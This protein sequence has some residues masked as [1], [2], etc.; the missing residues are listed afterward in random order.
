MAQY[1]LKS[2]FTAGEIAPALYGRPDLQYYAA[3]ARRLENFCV[4]PYGGITKRPGAMFMNMPYEQNDPDSIRLIPFQYSLDDSYMLEFGHKYMSVYKDGAPVT[5][6]NIIRESSGAITDVYVSTDGSVLI[7]KECECWVFYNEGAQFKIGT[8]LYT[9]TSRQ[10]WA[11]DSDYIQLTVA[12]GID[13][14]ATSNILYAYANSVEQGSRSAVVRWTKY[15]NSQNST[16]FD[17]FFSLGNV[18]SVDDFVFTV[19]G[20]NDDSNNVPVATA[21]YWRITT[22]LSAN[23]SITAGSSYR[24]NPFIKTE[25]GTTNPPPANDTTSTWYSAKILF[26]SSSAVDK[27]IVLTQNHLGQMMVKTSQQYSDVFVPGFSFSYWGETYTVEEVE[28]YVPDNA[29]NILILDKT[30]LSL[31]STINVLLTVNLFWNQN[32]WVGN[33]AFASLMRVGHKFVNNGIVYTIIADAP[34]VEDDG[35]VLRVLTAEPT[36]TRDS[37]IIRYDLSPWRESSAGLAGWYDIDVRVDVPEEPYVYTIGSP[38]SAD[39]LKDVSYAQSAD[40]LYLVSPEKVPYE[41]SRYGS[42]DW[43]FATFDYKDGPFSARTNADLDVSITFGGDALSTL[44]SEITAT[45]SAPMFTA[46]HVGALLTAVQSVDALTITSTGSTTM[47]PTTDTTAISF[48]YSNRSSST[49][50]ILVTTSNAVGLLSVGLDITIVDGTTNYIRTITAITQHSSGTYVTLN[51]PISGAVIGRTVTVNAQTLGSIESTLNDRNN[52][53]IELLCFGTWHV[54]THGFW[55]GSLA[56]QAFSNEENRWINLSIMNSD[57]DTTTGLDGSNYDLSGEVSEA[58]IIRVIPL[59]FFYAFTPTNN[60]D[61]SQGYVTLSRPSSLSRGIMKITD[62]LSN[63]MANGV[64]IQPFLNQGATTNWQQGAWSDYQ[65]YPTSVGF[66]EER[67]IFAATRREPQTVWFS[68]TGDYNNFGVS[69]PVV[70]DDAIT[71]TLSSRQLNKIEAIINTNNLILMT[72]STEWKITAASNGAI[73]PTNFSARVQGA[74]GCDILEPLIINSV[75]LFVQSKGSKVQDLLYSFE[76]DLYQGTD[77]SIL[78]PHIFS[79]AKVRDWCYQQEPNSIIWIV[80]D[81]GM[82]VSLTYMREHNVVAWARHPLGADATVHA[83]GCLNGREKDTLYLIVKRNNVISMETIE[84]KNINTAADGYFLDGGLYVTAIS[85]EEEDLIKSING[86]AHLEGLMVHIIEDGNRVVDKI[87]K[88]GQIMCDYP[89]RTVAVG[90]PYTAFAE[91]LDIAFDRND[92]TQL[93]RK[94][95]VPNMKIQVQKT[96]GL[97]ISSTGK[98]VDYI[99]VKDRSYEGQGS[100]INLYSG[101]LDIFVPTGWIYGGRM[102][103]KAPVG[104]PATINAIVPEVEVGGR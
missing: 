89:S 43:V 3:G 69:I 91:T 9:V 36:R 10:N 62:I 102:Y 24:C 63:I 5:T 19:T 93:T 95:K 81:D 84:F 55:S 83:C 53:S 29:F 88:D 90:I 23:M 26:F 28:P 101:D 54:V 80:R 31:T 47:T 1:P 100:P 85:D 57:P 45:A 46:G 68:K 37:G 52:W 74:R 94:I 7:H 27:H 30:F 13:P 39:E 49:S 70:D 73:T 35:T 11:V 96:R 64:V 56:I 40:V 59:T 14:T 82:L 72:S 76:T 104:L 51:Q 78:A 77:V 25:A 103:I 34:Q 50:T 32:G 12:E 15:M 21:N 99:E 33:A 17:V 6:T 44:G 86:L 97:L 58:T 92:G 87:V 65:G 20:S 41:L 67:L 8:K 2:S 16:S 42:T 18:F 71:R 61:S 98:D 79:E 75:V 60:T 22:C 66:F 4:Q 48:S 38:Y